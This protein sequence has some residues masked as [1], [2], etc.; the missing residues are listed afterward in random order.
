MRYNELPG[1]VHEF[2]Y[3]NIPL[4]KIYGILRL[5]EQRTI[6]KVK[7]YH[8]INADETWDTL[9]EAKAYA[10][11]MGDEDIH[12]WFDNLRYEEMYTQKVHILYLKELAYKLANKEELIPREL[13]VLLSIGKELGGPNCPVC[14]G[15]NVRTVADNIIWCNECNEHQEMPSDP[16]HG[17]AEEAS[18]DRVTF[19]TTGNGVHHIKIDGEVAPGEI[20]WLRPGYIVKNLPDSQAQTFK[21]IEV[22]KN[23]VMS[24]YGRWKRN[25]DHGELLVGTLC[26][27][28][29][30][31]IL[32]ED[33]DIISVKCD[34]C[35]SLF[36][37]SIED[38][39]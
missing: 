24:K 21:N 31:G 30:V 33:E 4:G 5:E 17:P 7:F 11:K 15:N 12:R 8:I 38:V 37:I 10:E 29:G 27:E 9:D 2:I 32:V 3:H 36:P 6:Y 28:C 20:V 1:N 13:E 14:Q 16:K 18:E 22:A 19:Y 39:K 26:P 23:Y 35:W 25:V 34:R